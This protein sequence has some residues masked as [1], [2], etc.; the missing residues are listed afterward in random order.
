MSKT[1]KAIFEESKKRLAT[2]FEKLEHL[3]ETK[4]VVNTN[5]ASPETEAE[6]NIL[7]QKIEILESENK[8][9][10]AECNM[11]RKTLTEDQ[12]PLRVDLLDELDDS[13]EYVEKLL[14]SK[15]ANN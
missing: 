3:I 9:L 4:L 13:I 8:K 5:A 10:E 7:K 6:L 11:L 12:E 2:A 1:N 15:N 14:K